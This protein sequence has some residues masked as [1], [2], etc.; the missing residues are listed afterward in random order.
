MLLVLTNSTDA[1]ADYLLSKMSAASVPFIR[2]DTDTL[3]RGV[4]FSYVTGRPQIQIANH[5]YI[6]DDF[7][8][9]WYRR[10]EHLLSETIPDSP[11]GKCVRDEW[12]EALEGFFAHIPRNRWVNYPA[13][14]A[15]ASRKLEQLTT[16]QSLGFVVPETCVTQT[17]AVLRDFF[18]HHHGEVIVKPLGNAYLERPD[19]EGDSVIFTNR[20]KATDL[21]DLTDLARCPTLFQQAVRKHSDIRITVIDDAIHAVELTANDDSGHQR[22]D[23]RRNN[24][25][26]V[27]YRTIE[28]PRD[29]ADKLRILM[30][31]Y[32]LRFAAIDMAIAEDGTW[33]FF[34]INP[35]GQWAWLDLCGGTAIYKSFLASFD[36]KSIR[37]A[38]GQ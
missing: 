25:A 8:T 27:T 13:D 36:A 18:A 33:Y 38:E 7:S 23:I 35:N 11:E 5:R 14:N 24:M 37:A 4:A 22:C 2:L 31:H 34:E 12:S 17:P 28:L 32:G 19:N 10:P 21:E 6:P 9:V 29:K 30:R 15:L 20:V 1:T 3:L 26:D 16:A